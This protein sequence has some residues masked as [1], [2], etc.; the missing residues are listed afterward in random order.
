MKSSKEMKFVDENV[1]FHSKFWVWMKNNQCKQ[2]NCEW[3]HQKR[4]NL[5]M[6]MSTSTQNSGSGWKIIDVNKPTL[7]EIIKKDEIC[8][9]KCAHSWMKKKTRETS[10]LWHQHAYVTSS[11][12]YVM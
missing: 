11:Y 12:F 7:D 1:H 6:K 2:T 4:W 10:Q 5:W 9:W 3:N 8:G